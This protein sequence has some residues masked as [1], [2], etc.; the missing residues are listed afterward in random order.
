MARFANKPVV[1]K[2]FLDILHSYQRTV[3]QQART[4]QTEKVVLD[5]VT[6]LFGEEPDLLEEFRHFLPGVHGFRGG[7]D[8]EVVISSDSDDLVREEVSDSEQEQG[9]KP[10][11]KAKAKIATSTSRPVTR[12]SNTSIWKRDVDIKEAAMTASVEDIV[13]FDKI[14]R[15]L[16]ERKHDTFLR[17]LNLYSASIISGTELL[18]MLENVFGNQAH[19]LDGLRKIL[20]VEDDSTAQ[21]TA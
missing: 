21:A 2:K 12:S 4:P 17:A 20:G 10:K 8:A 15:C 7:S 6:A 1:Y 16:D 3:D 19:L 14:R 13:Y 9:T 5:E 11:K 18:T